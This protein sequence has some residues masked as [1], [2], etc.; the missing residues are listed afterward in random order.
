M[1]LPVGQE[2]HLGCK[3]GSSIHS[4]GVE[5]PGWWAWGKAMLL[6]QGPHLGVSGPLPGGAH[7]CERALSRHPSLFQGWPLS[8]VLLEVLEPAS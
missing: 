6:R 4:L 3:E 5:C 8:L 7:V 2:E 1:P